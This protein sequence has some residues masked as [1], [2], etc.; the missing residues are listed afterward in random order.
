MRLIKNR[1]VISILL[2][3]LVVLVSWPLLQNSNY[4]LAKKG[5]INKEDVNKI[6][7][8]N[9]DAKI[10]LSKES[11]WLI[12]EPIKYLADSRKIKNLLENLEKTKIE[13]LVTENPEHYNKFDV[14]EEKGITVS[15]YNKDKLIKE[16]IIGKM[17]SNFFKSYVRIEK[18]VYLVDSMISHTFHINVD[19]LRDKKIFNIKKEKIASISIIKGKERKN[20]LKKD[21]KFYLDNKEYKNIENF[22]DNILNLKVHQFKK[23][24]DVIKSL[25]QPYLTIEVKDSD[26]QSYKLMVSEKDDTYKLSK[27]TLKK[28]ELY[29]TIPSYSL[30]QVHEFKFE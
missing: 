4:N 9:K 5:L 3:I 2:L 15:I 20:I 24:D 19:E 13:N 14:D 26:N 12:L 7:I 27:L 21:D 28:D 16:F 22:I 17:D 11:E 18:E 10:V 1:L 25:D 29:F 23:K 30:K 6:V 8:K